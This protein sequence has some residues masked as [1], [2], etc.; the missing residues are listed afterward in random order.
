[1]GFISI[2]RGFRLF[3]IVLSL[4][5]I[6]GCDQHQDQ[7]ISEEISKNSNEKAYEIDKNKGQIPTTLE[8][9]AQLRSAGKIN[10]AIQRLRSANVLSPENTDILFQLGTLYL[11]NADTGLAIISI[12]S[13]IEKG[14]KS[15]EAIIKLGSILANRN[16][17]NCLFYAQLLIDDK[18]RKSSY[19]G[20]FLQGIYFANINNDLEAMK[21]F[22]QSIIENYRFIDAYIEKAI[23]LYDAKKYKQSISLLQKGI[24]VDKYQADLYYWIGRNSEKLKD[25][26]ECIFAY[27][28]TLA[29]APDFANARTRLDSIRNILK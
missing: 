7:G 21:A 9:V 13:S 18:E 10:E 28:Q 1:M 6:S 29:L 25:F 20:Y 12:K 23:L 24:D 22:D 11:E 2:G 4:N 14:N 26:N 8:E 16:D 19:L 17:K 15:P 3:F 27:E 5:I